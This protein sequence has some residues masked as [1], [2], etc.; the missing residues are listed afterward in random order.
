MTDT[1]I[2][3]TCLALYAALWIVL[4]IL[5]RRHYKKRK[6]QLTYANKIYMSPFSEPL[7]LPGED[8]DLFSGERPYV[9]V[10][11]GCN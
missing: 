2:F 6:K 7:D 9:H 11:T 4:F 8:V 1:Q 10:H 3:A 5:V